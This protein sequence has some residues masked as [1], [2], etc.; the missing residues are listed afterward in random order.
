[1]S[2]SCLDEYWEGEVEGFYI[3]IFVKSKMRNWKIEI[4]VWIQ[5]KATLRALLDFC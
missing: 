1:M 3:I 2:Y 5:V 4:T